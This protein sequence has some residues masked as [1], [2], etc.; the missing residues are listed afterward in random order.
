MKCGDRFSMYFVHVNIMSK[1]VFRISR[2]C[3]TQ[4]TNAEQ[5]DY[6]AFVAGIRTVLS[7]MKVPVGRPAL[8]LV[9]EYTDQD[10]Y[11]VADCGGS[12]DAVALNLTTTFGSIIQDVM[13]KDGVVHFSVNRKA[14]V[15]AVHTIFKEAPI[16]EV[17]R[18]RRI[19]HSVLTLVW[20]VLLAVVLGLL[21]YTGKSALKNSLIVSTCSQLLRFVVL[22]WIQLIG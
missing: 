12:A 4:L 15:N 1:E 2:V 21:L 22:A 16:Q 18:S 5:D 13:V 11:L 19:L 14:A 9:S 7:K 20:L 6:N 17:H 10:E 8:A 3:N